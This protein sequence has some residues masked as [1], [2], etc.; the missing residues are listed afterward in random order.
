VF[1]GTGGF[2][3]GISD[4][5]FGQSGCTAAL[6]LLLT[7][8]GNQNDYHQITPEKDRKKRI[9]LFA[10]TFMVHPKKELP[11]E[12]QKKD[13]PKK[14]ILPESAFKILVEFLQ[15]TT[16]SDEHLFPVLLNGSS[17]SSLKVLLQ[18]FKFNLLRDPEETRLFPYEK[19][20]VH[21]E[22]L[23]TVTNLENFLLD[24]VT[25]PPVPTPPPAP[26][27]SKNFENLLQQQQVM[28]DKR[29]LLEKNTQKER[30]HRRK[31]RNIGKNEK[32]GKSGESG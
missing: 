23:A 13:I 19:N 15:Q 10:N 4:F 26:P 16:S 17:G 8:V 2:V 30:T 25:R 24:H 5:E 3:G 6:L 31:R 14:E 29:K 21:V 12:S 20:Q 1:V 32:R 22:P 27:A 9:N 28:E 18:P 7:H 11:P